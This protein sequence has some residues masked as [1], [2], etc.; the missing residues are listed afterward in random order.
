MYISQTRPQVVRYGLSLGHDVSF[1]S[2]L[3]FNDVFHVVVVRLFAVIFKSEKSD[4]SK[5]EKTNLASN[6]HRKN[7]TKQNNKE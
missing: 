3:N 7:E 2:V 5:Q 1:D 6:I 4:K